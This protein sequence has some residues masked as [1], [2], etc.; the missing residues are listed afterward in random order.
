MPGKDVKARLN[1]NVTFGMELNDSFPCSLLRGGLFERVCFS[2]HSI[3]LPTTQTVSEAVFSKNN[4]FTDL[5]YS[6][7]EQ[8]SRER[9]ILNE[10]LNNSDECILFVD[11]IGV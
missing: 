8:A 5:C 3:T 9:N 10:A 4:N 7:E 2:P 6:R 11:R 1:S